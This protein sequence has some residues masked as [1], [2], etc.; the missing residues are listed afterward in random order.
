M[1]KPNFKEIN[2]LGISPN[3]SQRWGTRPRLWVL[4]TEEGNQD[5]LGLARY[6]QNPA[7]EVSYH[8]TADNAIVVDVVDTDFASWSV[9]D[10][11]PYCINFCFAGSRASQSRQV[12]LDKFGN[13]IAAS[14]WLFV[15]DAKKYG[16][17][18]IRELTNAEVGKGL[19]GGT[20]HGGITYGLGIGNHTDVGLNFPWDVWNARVA[21]YLNGEAPKP[22]IPVVPVPNKIAEIA[23]VSPWL[24]KKTTE[25]DELS[26]PDGR[27]KYAFFENGA[28]YFTPETEA[29]P[30]PKYLLDPFAQLG[31]ETGPLGYPVAFHTIL[32]DGEVQAFERGVLY[33]KGHP[34]QDEKPGYFVTGLIGERWKRSGFEGGP[35][36]WP[37]SNEVD[38]NGGKYQDFEKGRITFDPS[39]VVGEVTH[40]AQD[41][42]IEDVQK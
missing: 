31:Y 39:M 9:L 10:A 12:W 37:I 18:N 11:N 7:N 25:G 5:A 4:H 14:A 29:R 13:A 24:G 6:L 40:G 41:Q 32:P 27:G 15:E 35:F 21:E 8:Y 33:R 38:F 30:I 19:S 34:G 36:G 1:A 2:Q 26:C 23:K 16:F 42:L 3:K 17:K 20:D 22:P 28:V